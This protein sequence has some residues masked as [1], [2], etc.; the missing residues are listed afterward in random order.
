MTQQ[1]KAIEIPF[2]AN[3]SELI[4]WEYT[5]PKGMEAEIKDGKVIIKK[6]ESED[7]RIKKALIDGVRQIRCKN[8]ITQEQ[9]IAYLEKQKEQ[10]P[11]EPNWIHHKV[12]LSDCSEEYIKAYYDGWNNCNQQHAQHDAEQKPAE[13]ILP[14]EFEEAV[15]KVAN[16]ISPFDSQE[17][18]RKVS[19]RFAEQ[20]LSLAKKELD[21][22]AE[23]S[24]EDE[25]TLKDIIAGLEAT[26]QLTYKHEP[27]GRACYNRWIAWLKSLPERFNIQPKPEWSEEDEGELQ[28]AI[29]AL[30]FLGKKGVYKSESGYDAALQAASWLK[31]LPE[32]LVLQPKQEWDEEDEIMIGSLINYFEGD[33]L[34]CSTEDVVNWLKSLHPQP[35]Q[36][37]SVED[38]LMIKCCF[39]A[40][41]HYK[42]TG[43]PNVFCPSQFDIDGY[44]TSPE[45]V[46]TWLESLRNRP[47]PSDTWKPSE[48]QMKALSEAVYTFDGYEESDAIKSLYNDIKK[49]M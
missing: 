13:W 18:L 45:K 43:K 10:K 2:G 48:E 6:A 25:E 46:Q 5:I 8:G 26:K 31:D 21:K 24:E 44:L 37:W 19:H 17:K 38:E 36:E 47:K 4:K 28:N 30:E 32:R 34:D 40:I 1:E 23:W 9:M 11:V 41:E 22:P 7:E 29:D 49:L 12:D 15:Y 14:E 27:S 39:R 33:A 16:F 35:K 42:Y 20:L 3:D